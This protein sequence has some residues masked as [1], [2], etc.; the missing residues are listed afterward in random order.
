VLAPAGFVFANLIIYW[1]GFEA[2]WKLLTGIFIGRVVFEILLRRRDD[3]R[4][5]DIDWR[6]ASWIWPWLIGMTIIGLLGR[7]GN[8]AH[9]TLPEWIDLLVVAAWSLVIFYCAVSLAM[10]AEQVAAAVR[11]EQEQ[12]AGNDDLRTA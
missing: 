3:V 7:Y 10:P 2:T 6:A 5:E 9:D 1:G 4:R 11:I 12:E 8:G